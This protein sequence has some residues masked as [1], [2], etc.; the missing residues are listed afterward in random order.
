MGQGIWAMVLEGKVLGGRVLCAGHWG[1]VWGLG[2]GG[3]G[4]CGRGIK[5]REVHH[6]A[7][8]KTHASI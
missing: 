2:I 6:T 4:I 3:Q 8:H 7:T 1:M 5:Y